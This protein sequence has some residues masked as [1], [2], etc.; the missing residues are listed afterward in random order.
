MS[1]TPPTYFVMQSA[2][3]RDQARVRLVTELLTPTWLTGAKVTDD[4]PSPMEY[5]IRRGYPGVVQPF[6][7]LSYPLMR[8]DL[9]GALAASGVDNL[10]V[11]P[12]V[13][14]DRN[15]DARH[16]NYKAVNIVGVVAAADPAGSEPSE[17]SDS[18]IIDASFESLAIDAKRAGGRLLFRL[19]ESV[20][21]V[22]AHARVKEFVA[23][24]VPGIEF[25]EPS[26]WSG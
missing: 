13:I 18:E 25:V 26:E 11:F 19:A 3:V 2:L 24:R 21:A 22:I 20:N 10:Q 12:A 17:M 16:T 4:V 15:S 1:D 5:E 7:D 8:E 6:Y 9:V 14:V 23:P